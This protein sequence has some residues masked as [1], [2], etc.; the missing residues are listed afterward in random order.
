M[1]NIQ[2]AF[3]AMT[4]TERIAEQERMCEEWAQRRRIVVKSYVLYEDGTR[5]FATFYAADSLR[6]AFDWIRQYRHHTLPGKRRA[7]LFVMREGFP[8]YVK[9]TPRTGRHGA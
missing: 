6:E 7:R 8:A 3:E 1:T 5:S 4:P 2:R 9:R